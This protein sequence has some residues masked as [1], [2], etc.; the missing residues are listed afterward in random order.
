MPSRTL[1]ERAY[2]LFE[3][4]GPENAA[5][6]R[7]IVRL[8][9][10]LHSKPKDWRGLRLLDL[11]CGE[12]LFALEA[13][14]HGADVIAIDGR[15]ER[16]AAG[17][18]LAEELGLTSVQFIQADVRSHPFEQHG[19]FDSVLCLG[20]L[21]HLDAAGLFQVIERAARATT[22]ALILETH[23]SRSPDEAVQHEGATYR[24]WR[25]REHRPEDAEEVRRERLL[26]SLSND[27]SLWLTPESLFALLQRVGFP[28][29][30][31]CHVPLQPFQGEDRFTLVGLK[32]D[33]PEVLSFPWITQA[34]EDEVRRRARSQRQILSMPPCGSVREDAITDVVVTLGGWVRAHAEFVIG[35]P[36]AAAA[37][38]W[39]RQDLAEYT[40]GLRRVPPVL[41]VEVAGVGETEDELRDAAACALDA[42]V[43]VVWLVLPEAGS[44]VVVAPQVTRRFGAGD[45][46]P[47]PP[48]LVGF[49]PP[50][51]A[52]LRQ[53]P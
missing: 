44:V 32:G 4:K 1:P 46:L 3:A 2:A 10:A 24:G 12:G 27:S 16:M 35:A 48:G 9:S 18:A 30:L 53:V 11:G 22:R 34:A 39:R 33:S 45:V 21:Y 14:L 51:S 26:A 25:Y 15:D 13:A 28:S 23:F 31:Q 5:R 42:G 19:P 6:V 49:S 8:I 47:E 52:L 7:R 41:S 40:G 43:A 37:A 17:R 50:V 29:V 20:L 36:H 38:I